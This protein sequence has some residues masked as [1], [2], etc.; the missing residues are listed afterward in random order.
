MSIAV[1]IVENEH[2]LSH[3]SI[4]N[5]F[6]NKSFI[7]DC[8]WYHVHNHL[9]CKI[10]ITMTECSCQDYFYFKK[11]RICV[12]NVGVISGREGQGSEVKWM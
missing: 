9:M 5:L 2:K 10:S 8:L 1:N 4:G 12:T 7:L 3:N 6:L 11:N